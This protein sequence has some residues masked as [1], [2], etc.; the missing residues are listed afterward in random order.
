MLSLLAGSRT[1]P[2]FQGMLSF[3]RGTTYEKNRN[4]GRRNTASVGGIIVTN[5]GGIFSDNTIPA[6]VGKS[7]KFFA[8]S[9]SHCTQCDFHSSPATGYPRVSRT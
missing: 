7:A 9:I 3:G 4:C 2:V 8:V 6:E 5:L 1:S